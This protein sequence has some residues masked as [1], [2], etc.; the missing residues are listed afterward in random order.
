MSVF[1]NL[2]IISIIIILVV[3]ILV[4]ISSF[5][6][7]NNYKVRNNALLYIKQLV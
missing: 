4:I 3:I 1:T 2:V 7:M 5:L 6:N